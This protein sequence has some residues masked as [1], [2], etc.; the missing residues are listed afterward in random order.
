MGV[1]L[2][3]VPERSPAPGLPVVVSEIS[4]VTFRVCMCEIIVA[5]AKQSCWAFSRYPPPC[6]GRVTATM[7]RGGVSRGVDEQ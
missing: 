5:S 7:F 4:T 1:C 2:P 3:Y 6:Q